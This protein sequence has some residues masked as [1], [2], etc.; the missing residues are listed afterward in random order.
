[1]HC[2]HARKG[3][4]TSTLS[5]DYL[6]L[7]FKCAGIL[8]ASGSVHHVLV[9]SPWRPGEATRL[10]EVRVTDSCEPVCVLRIKPRS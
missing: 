3:Q 1:M 7:V 8:P 4:G 5:I 6:Y 10:S 9:W 2:R